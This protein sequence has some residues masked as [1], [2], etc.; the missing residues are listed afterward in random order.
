MA[1]NKY[2]SITTLNVN[3]LNAPIKRHGVA[4]WII[5]QKP[6][7]CYLQETHVSAKDTYKL[8]VRG[9]KKIF[10]ANGQDRKTGVAILISDKIDFKMK[11]IKK[12]KE[13][14]H[15]MIKRLIQEKYITH[16]CICLNI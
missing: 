15:L 13:R 5:K 16:Q 11:A 14:H 8:K 3:G 9:R 12:D 1:I 7:I 4:D 6:T 10:H 2:L